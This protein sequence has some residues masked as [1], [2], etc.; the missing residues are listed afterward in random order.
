MQEQYRKR[1]TLRSK[2]STIKGLLYAP[3]LEKREIEMLRE[4]PQSDV[5][6]LERYCTNVLLACLT[7]V[8]R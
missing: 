1:T 2:S 3:D 8:R 5:S 4:K 7:K 6:R